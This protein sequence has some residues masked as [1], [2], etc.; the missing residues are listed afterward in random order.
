MASWM[1]SAPHAANILGD[2]TDFGGAA[3]VDAMGH[4]W[5]CAVFAVPK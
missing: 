2:Y 3:A 1:G 4:C 5:W